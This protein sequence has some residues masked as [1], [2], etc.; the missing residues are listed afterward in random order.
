MVLSDGHYV[1]PGEADYARTFVPLAIRKGV[2]V[3]HLD[4]DGDG[5][6]I[7]YGATRVNVAGLSPVNVARLVGM[8]AQQEMKRADKGL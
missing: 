1:A 7:T 2:A 6:C 3:L 5:S 8:A 4:F